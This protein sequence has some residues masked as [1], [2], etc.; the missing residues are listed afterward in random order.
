MVDVPSPS[1]VVAERKP[2]AEATFFRKTFD[3]LVEHEFHW[4]GALFKVAFWWGAAFLGLILAFFALYRVK[5]MLAAIP[6]VIQAACLILIAMAVLLT[7]SMLRERGRALDAHRRF[8][9][10]LENLKPATD[11]ERTAGLPQAKISALRRKV[12]A[13]PGKPGEWWLAIEQS[14]EYY[15]SPTGNE[16]WFLTRSVPECLPEEDVVDSFYNSAFHQSVPG[17]LTALGLLATFVAILMALAGVTYNPRDAMRPVSG[18]DQLING[19]SGKFLS[20]IVALIL[21]VI[22]TLLEK[23]IC[24]RQLRNSY[25]ALTKRCRDVFPFLTQSRI[26]LDIQRIAVAQSQRVNTA[27]QRAAALERG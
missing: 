21:S 15:T 14:M 6:P 23:K 24:D 1:D 17:I 11:A 9:T 18:I 10:A 4:A 22:F 5:G 27:E 25:D 26:L 2:A 3:R 7:R 20:S 12:G 16:G 13:L 19:L 8:L